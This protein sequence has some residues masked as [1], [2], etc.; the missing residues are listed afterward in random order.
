MQ[1]LGR[2]GVEKIIHIPERLHD[3]DR[4]VRACRVTGPI[5]ARVSKVTEH[6]ARKQKAAGPHEDH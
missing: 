2:E 4:C 5:Q 3:L 6:F 1:R